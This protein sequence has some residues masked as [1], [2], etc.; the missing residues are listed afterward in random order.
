[1]KKNQFLLI[2]QEK[3]LNVIKME[4]ISEILSMEK[5]MVKEFFNGK[6]KQDMLVI[7]LKTEDKVKVFFI[8]NKVLELKVN[9]NSPK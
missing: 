1:M 3:V 4:N 6:T 5:D 2:I 7:L 8:I 9:L